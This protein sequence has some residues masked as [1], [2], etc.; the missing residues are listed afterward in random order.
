[1]K[2]KV[3][4]FLSRFFGTSLDFRVRLFNVL[5]MAGTLI[6]LVMVFGN[7]STGLW[8]SVAVSGA[9]T[10]LSA[11][12]LWYSAKTGRYRLCYLITIT[13][14]FLVMFPVL[15]FT[16]GGYH[17]GML[18]F[19]VFALV[20]TVLM[21]DKW[22]A[23]ILSGLE[24]AVYV[25]ICLIAYF[26]PET[27][28]PFVSEAARLTDVLVS[29]VTVSLSCGIVLYL[30]LREYDRQKAQLERQKEVLTAIDR[31]KTEFLGNISHELKTPL[32][33]VSGYAQD[34]R[35]VLQTAGPEALATV[36]RNM[37]VITA[38]ANR[39]A[40][41]V[42]QLLDMTAIDEGGIRLHKE[43]I[44]PVKLIQDTLN[45]YYPMLFGRGG[46][47]S[48]ER[49]GS[50]PVLVCDAE[51]HWQVLI[52]LL[53]N[54]ARHAQ[55]GHITVTLSR[56]GENAVFSVADDG[57]GISPDILPHIFERYRREENKTG[58]GRNTGTGLGLYIS[59]FLVEAHGGTIWAESTPG[60]GTTV[61]FT[62][63]V[64]TGPSETDISS[65]E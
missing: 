3:H 5:A 12:L 53:S 55:G 48:L 38:E 41:M 21:L 19:F 44:S 29:F 37:N 30:H 47:I 58:D 36:D 51:R 15:F 59:K 43:A 4:R 1:M 45:T 49:K 22:A 46:T 25:T 6:S 60:Q 28:L 39:L 31:Q 26:R 11:G 17:G 40:L 64:Q 50:V 27:V 16:S 7:L 8:V 57:G 52:N 35:S 2:A 20:F 24:L 33:V 32:T 9:S 62:I 61:W 54:A 63:P 56:Q 10:V 42:S 34:S 18:A 65:P 14:I 23:V 13:A